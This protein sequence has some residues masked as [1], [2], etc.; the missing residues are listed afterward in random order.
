MACIY[1]EANPTEC[2]GTDSQVGGNRDEVYE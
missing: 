1:S 2:N